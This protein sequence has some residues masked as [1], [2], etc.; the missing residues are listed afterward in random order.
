MSRMPCSLIHVAILCAVLYKCVMFTVPC[1]CIWE[2][3]ALKIRVIYNDYMTFWIIKFFFFFLSSYS[4][5]LFALYHMI[6]K[7]NRPTNLINDYLLIFVLYHSVMLAVNKLN[8]HWY[9]S[10]INCLINQQYVSI[11]QIHHIYIY[12]L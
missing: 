1:P 4:H 9:M 12:I 7:R 11:I 10:F 2:C 8:N 6:K 3:F 5:F